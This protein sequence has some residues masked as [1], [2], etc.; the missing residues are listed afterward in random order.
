MAKK[1]LFKIKVL[2]GSVLLRIPPQLVGAETAN[3]DEIQ[4][5]LHLMDV[6]YVPDKLL[7]IYQKSSG[8]F[9][10]LCDEINKEFNLV[11]EI[12]KDE[13]Q[14]FLNIMPPKDDKKILSIEKIYSVL[15]EKGIYQGINKKTIE[16]MI[17]KKIYYEPTIVALGKIP[18]HGK[19]GFAELLFVPEK[20]KPK[21]G[22]NYNLCQIP[23]LQKVKSGQ[24]LVR[25]FS[26]SSGED[27]YTITGKVLGAKAGKE[28]QIMP[29]RNT[30]YTPDRNYIISN[31]DGVVCQTGNSI[32]V[33]KIKIF[34]RVDSSTGHIRFDGVIKI[35]GNVSDRFNIEGVRVDVGGSVGRARIRSLGDIRVS[36]GINGSI[37]QA[38]GSVLAHSIVNAQVSASEN[39]VVSESIE[40]S[41][42]AAGNNLDMP[43]DKGFVSGGSIQAGNIIR[44][45]QVGSNINKNENQENT[46]KKSII[47]V[48]ISLKNRKIF[49]KLK[50]NI[51]NNYKIFDQEIIGINAILDNYNKESDK[52][53]IFELLN[54]K[55][56]SL[57]N[58][59]NLIF[60][61]SKKISL[62]KKIKD[63]NEK[64]KGGIVFIIGSV[65]VGT[66]INVRR[67]RYNVIK[68][69]SS[70]A[71]FFSQNG[72]QSDDCKKLIENFK[73][74]FIELPI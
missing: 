37:I 2:D 60:N 63:K 31:L 43:N 73:D 33:E 56:E 12:N 51:S 5:N 7:E 62:L 71:Y 50:D 52:Q 54:K 22:I 40:N 26:S 10:Y 41:S 49:K 53:K 35:R 8:D 67:M 68:S 19:N 13:S 38:G 48:G 64:L 25:L 42:I 70:K 14:V 23:L 30:K 72:V 17:E 29:G 34:D 24:K 46:N 36:Q 1:E 32:S 15:H 74:L 3:I 57:K 45:P 21:F 58:N 69:T 20:L 65:Q 18:V 66:I 61:N 59:C 27:G 11:I 9:D 28:F 16:N 39:I 55:S 4:E 6:D 47:D 44:I